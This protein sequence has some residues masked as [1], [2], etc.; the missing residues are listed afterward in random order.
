[1]STRAITHL[2]DAD[3]QDS[4]PVWLSWA[5]VY[6]RTPNSQMLYAEEFDRNIYA[7]DRSL[8]RASMYSDRREV[9]R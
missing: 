8:S 5:A 4:R 3:V 1:M 6:N 2:P 9:R 7:V